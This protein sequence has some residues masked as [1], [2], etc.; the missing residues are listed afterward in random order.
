MVEEA[1][2]VR[3]AVEGVDFF[4]F[5]D[6]LPGCRA[7]RFAAEEEEGP[8]GVQGQEV[9]VGKGE[10]GAVDLV[11]QVPGGIPVGEVEPHAEVG[12]DNGLDA[13]VERAGV[14][15]DFSAHGSGP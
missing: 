1:D 14:E 10:V 13:F 15:G 12:G 7:V 8:G 6:V 3:F 5:V 4:G 9:V 2:G 11:A